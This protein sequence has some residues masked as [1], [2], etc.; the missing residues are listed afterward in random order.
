MEIENGEE[1][2]EL[3][4][5]MALLGGA[6]LGEVDLVREMLD[7]GMNINGI[8][9]N[10][11]FSKTIEKDPDSHPTVS[12]FD[13]PLLVAVKSTAHNKVI[14]L[15][16]ERGADAELRDENG[17]TALDIARERKLYDVVK[18]LESHEI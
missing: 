7:K 13:T 4:Y 10:T 15:L 1:K 6:M 18:I 14:K 11:S 9:A 3:A 2:K 8:I 17:K 5:F 12:Q 16:L